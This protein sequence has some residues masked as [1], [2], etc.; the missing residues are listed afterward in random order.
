MKIKY[1]I[2]EDI[3]NY[4]KISMVIGFPYCSFKCE[5]ECGVKC[6]Q[7]SSLAKMPNVEISAESIV[8]RYLNNPIT[9]SVV[10]G[11]LE[12]LDSWEDVYLLIT[13]LRAYVEDNVVIF[14]GYKEE[15]IADKI[16]AL[17]KFPNII[18][19]FGRFIPNQSSHK[20]EV[21]GVLL[22]SPNQYAKKI[23]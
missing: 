9:S 15:E 3:V 10:F 17:K 19:K 12:P 18:I 22:A 14:T 5:T 11:G 20:D 6:C 1:I 16:E 23:S 7:N 8:D 13:K 21:L 4:K 2:D